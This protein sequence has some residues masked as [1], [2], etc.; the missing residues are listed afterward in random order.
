MPGGCPGRP[1]QT[2]LRKVLALPNKVKHQKLVAVGFRALGVAGVV[3]RALGVAGVVLALGVA[4]VVFGGQQ[5]GPKVLRSGYV[6][7]RPAVCMC[8]CICI[9]ICIPLIPE[10]SGTTSF[11]LAPDQPNG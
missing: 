3:F 1:G 10:P 7:Q 6:A 8:I 5:A 9:C 4:G 2:D 11:T